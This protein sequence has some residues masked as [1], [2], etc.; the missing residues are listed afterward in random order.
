L[1][2]SKIIAALEIAVKN[3]TASNKQSTPCCS[4]CGSKLIQREPYCPN[5]LCKF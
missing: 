4:E 5:I 3:L 1:E 2:Q